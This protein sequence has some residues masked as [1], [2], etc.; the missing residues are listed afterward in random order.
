MC[1]TVRKFIFPAVFLAYLLLLTPGSCLRTKVL[2]CYFYEFYGTEFVDEMQ[3]RR[4]SSAKC[5]IQA[6]VHTLDTRLYA[7]PSTTTI[8]EGGCGFC[9]NTPSIMEKQGIACQ[10]CESD[11]CNL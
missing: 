10:D 6:K 1:S 11:L 4:C 3:I 2:Y 5:Y 8:L 7:Q 9:A